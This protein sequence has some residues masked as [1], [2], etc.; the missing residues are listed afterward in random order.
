MDPRLDEIIRPKQSNIYLNLLKF[1]FSLRNKSFKSKILASTPL[2][3]PH[4][5]FLPLHET[6]FQQRVPNF[7]SMQ[8][9]KNY[10]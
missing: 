10:S 8:K 5:P 1:T 6:I 2:P 3:L 4:Q 7:R 9:Q